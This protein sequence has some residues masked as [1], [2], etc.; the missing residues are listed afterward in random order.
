MEK[1]GYPEVNNEKTIFMKRKEHN[2]I[3]HGL[4]V[5]DMMHVPTCDALKQEL[6][7]KYTKDFPNHRRRSNGDIFG[8]AGRAIEWQDMSTP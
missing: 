3:V 1:N 5:D 7:A 6:M 2:F 4:F 8:H